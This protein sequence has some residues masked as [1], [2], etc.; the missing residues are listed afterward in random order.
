MNRFSAL[1]IASV[2]FFIFGC[3][4]KVEPVTPKAE[5]AVT[6]VGKEHLLGY[7][8]SSIQTVEG[9]LHVWLHSTA[10]I[11][12]SEIAAGKVFEIFAEIACDKKQLKFIKTADNEGDII[13]EFNNSDWTSPP[14]IT[15]AY[16][17]IATVCT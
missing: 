2:A 14:S 8:K 13:E 10:P 7:Y 17:I 11:A 5:E 6:Y 1:A 3:D 12:P 4:V 16:K 15:E 9:K